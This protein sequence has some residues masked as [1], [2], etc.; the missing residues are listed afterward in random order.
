MED[1]RLLGADNEL[2]ETILNTQITD[3]PGGGWRVVQNTET[4]DPS[5]VELT[6]NA[7]CFDNTP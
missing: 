1:S 3:P 2:T 4:A 7:Y 6:V 5:S